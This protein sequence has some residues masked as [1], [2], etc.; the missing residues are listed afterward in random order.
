M[1]HISLHDPVINLSLLQ[2]PVFQFAWLQ[3]IRHTDSW[4]LT[5]ARVDGNVEDEG[6]EK[7]STENPFK[8]N[9]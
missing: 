8:V 9:S 1:S 4:L 7:V 3:C 6:M 5:K 2:T